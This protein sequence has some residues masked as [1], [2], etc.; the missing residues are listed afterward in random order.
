[1]KNQA[2]NIESGRAIC[3]PEMVEI[4]PL[5]CGLKAERSNNTRLILSIGKVIVNC[6]TCG[7]ELLKPAAWA[8]RVARHY[9]SQVCCGIGKRQRR[10]VACVVCG[11]PMLITPAHTGRTCSKECWR[12]LKSLTDHLLPRDEKGRMYVSANLPTSNDQVKGLAR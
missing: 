5:C 11:V 2:R 10:K 4:A 6:E 7:L 12:Q 8:K 1:M 9:C 3:R